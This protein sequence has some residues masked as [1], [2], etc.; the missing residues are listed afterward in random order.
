MKLGTIVARNYLAQARVLAASLERLDDGPQLS[1]LVLDDEGEL[2]LDDSR[3]PFEIVRPRDLDIAPREFHHMATIYDVTELATA[4]KPWFLR[5]LLESDDV[6]CFLDPDIEVFSSLEEIEQLARSHSIVLTPHTTRPMPRDGKLPSEETIRLAGV[7]NLGFIA[8]SREA[9]PFLAWWSERL[10]RDCRIAVARGLF[11]DQ[12]WVDFVPSY[13][14]HAVLHDD[15][16]NVAYW[17]MHER[18]VKLGSNGYEVNGR[19]LKFLHYSGFDPLR[20]HL[21][22]KYQGGEPRILL[23]DHF[24]IAHLCHRYATRLFAAGHL[25]ASAAPYRFGYTAHGVVIDDR[26]RR[27]YTEALAGEEARG[28]TTSLPDPF[29]PAGAE[30]FLAWLAAPGRSGPSAPV[31]RYLCAVYDEHDHLAERFGD[32][33][34]PGGEEYLDWIC[35]HGRAQLAVHPE[36]MPPP[37]VSSTARPR[38]LKE[39]VNLVGYLRA[40]DGVG[41]VARATLDV[42][43]RTGSDVS[44]RNCTVT[45][46]RQCAPVYEARPDEHLTYDTTIACINADQFPLLNAQLG[47]NMPV[48]TTTVGI[49]A[50]EVEVFP[51]WMA[52]SAALVDEIWTYSAHG[53]NA[54]AA[55]CSVPVHVFAPPVTI[56]ERVGDVDRAAVGVTEDFT[57]LTCFDFASVFDRKNPLA[58][59]DAFKTAFPRGDGPRLVVKSVNGMAAPREWARMQAAAEGRADVEIR[60]GYEPEARQRELTAACDCYVSLHRAEGYGLVLAESMAAAKP[61]IATAYSGN[62]E[63]MT[64]ETSVLVPYELRPIPLGCAPYPSTASWAE[65]DLDSAARAM[66]DLAGD[67]VAAA[68]MGAKAREHIARH[69]SADARV[70]FV[71]ARLDALRSNR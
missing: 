4:L 32:L 37:E 70:A 13:F 67:P 34:G 6:A 25:E 51:Q 33:S 43:R 41:A 28:M 64:P 50:W 69:H 14:E 47:T 49:W 16:Y 3:E 59:I 45:R 9:G 22:S 11:V 36:F 8:V 60:D 46:S 29:T 30:S 66:R 5:Q 44:L 58:V 53:A 38:E 19:P 12:R 55:A 27:V 15:G 56:P 39:G 1:V 71:R 63:F 54:I 21:L 10:R 17:N 61:V 18:E 24:E 40:E 23:E 7:F 26:M 20:P 35:R 48:A 65:P 42:I 52:R 31:S 57:F 2:E 68:K 62:L